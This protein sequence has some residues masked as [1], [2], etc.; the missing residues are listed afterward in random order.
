MFLL[1]HVCVYLFIEHETFYFFVS[2]LAIQH[3]HI[4]FFVFY[5]FLWERGLF[6][7]FFVCLWDFLVLF[8]FDWLLFVFLCQL[9]GEDNHSFLHWKFIDLSLPRNYLLFH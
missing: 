5:F 3:C 1:V 8:L 6:G 7:V 9:L 2:Y 4:L